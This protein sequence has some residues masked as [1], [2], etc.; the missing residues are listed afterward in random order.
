MVGCQDK[1][2]MAELEEFK[3]QAAVEEQNKEIVR[4][5]FESV[6][7]GDVES[8][9]ALVDEIFA[10]EAIDATKDHIKFAFDTFGDMQHDLEEM[11]AE[12][13]IVS[14]RGTFQAT[15]KGNFF[16]VEPT[17]VKLSCLS[18]WMFRVKEGKIQESWID[19]D[20]LYNILT[21]QLGMELK[22]KEKDF[23]QGSIK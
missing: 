22:P 3:A 20:S 8:L 14:I 1:E 2:A 5:Y 19:W 15:H 16:G 21:T 6:D 4:R 11:I 23:G 18:L 17:G 13:D 10:P 12:E 9:Y 7:K